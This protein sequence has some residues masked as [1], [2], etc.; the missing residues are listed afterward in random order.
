MISF[1][2]ISAFN[3][4][5]FTGTS[6]D[7]VATGMMRGRIGNKGGVGISLKMAGTTLLFVNG[8]LAG[9]DHVF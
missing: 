9:N 7:T 3:E 2:E 1:R 5:K 8:H 4:E 6:K